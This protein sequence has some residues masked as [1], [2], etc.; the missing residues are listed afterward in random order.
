[1]HHTKWIYIAAV[2]LF[3]IST[4]WAAAALPDV[5]NTHFG[6][7]GQ[8]NGSMTRGGYIAFSLFLST[9][10]VALVP[11]A[12][13]AAARRPGKFSNIGNRGYWARPEN[14]AAFRTRY[15][16]LC[17]MIGAVCALLLTGGNIVIVTLNS[18]SRRPVPLPVLPTVVFVAVLVGA[19]A[20][21]Y[22]WYGRRP[23]PPRHDH[24]D[25]QD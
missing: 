14:R 17:L 19:F 5:V 24:V 25:S 12:G 15:I 16:G 21:A 7:S 13:T 18:G 8:P 3:A 9:F 22:K 4:V 11:L 20:A 10:S 1:M 6:A 2:G 23:P